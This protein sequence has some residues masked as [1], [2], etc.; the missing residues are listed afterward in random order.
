M[1]RT[2]I[3]ACAA[4]VVAVAAA[5]A[6]VVHDRDT[7][8]TGYCAEMPDAIGLYEGNPVTQMGLDVGR[9]DDVT[10]AGDHV[11]VTFTLDGEREFPADVKAVTRSKSVLADRSMELIGN[12][13]DG[14]VLEPGHCIALAATATPKSLSEIAGSAA[15]FLD[16]LSPQTQQAVS[17]SV[18]GLARALDGQGPEVHRLM[19][20]AAD[21]MESPD[22]MVADIGSILAN[23][24]PLTSDA[25]RDWSTV[26]DVMDLLPTVVT[27]LA[28]E[29]WPG[30]KDTIVAMG[31]LIAVLYEIQT[32]YGDILWP[33]SDRLADVLHLA[34]TRADDIAQFLDVLPTVSS[35]MSRTS[36]DATVRFTPPAM[37]LPNGQNIGGLDL[38]GL[39]LAGRTP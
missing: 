32:Q 19:L 7:A 39:V 16:Q 29:A 30:V 14:P 10:P 23:S 37:I 5:S 3:F 33:L 2:I 21:A 18:S 24:A 1:N 31:P 20:H 38:F 36:S 25:L 13:D 9:I 22:R 35:F 15:D 17:E 4:A 34:A 12:Y 27:A 28:H 6:Y 11:E 26:H 8:R